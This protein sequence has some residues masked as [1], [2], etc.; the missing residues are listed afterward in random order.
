[1]QFTGV[2]KVLQKNS[3]RNGAKQVWPFE[4]SVASGGC[5]NSII[6]LVP[7]FSYKPYVLN[8]LA[9]RKFM[10]KQL[11][12]PMIF[13]QH[14]F[15]HF[16]ITGDILPTPISK[17]TLRPLDLAIQSG[18]QVRLRWGGGGGRCLKQ[19]QEILIR[20]LRLEEIGPKSQHVFPEAT[21]ATF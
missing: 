17:C 7:C 8:S 3:P 1:M 13:R 11:S 19:S 12:I 14:N 9:G 6:F 21:I 15:T 5:K 2:M 16:G 4:R 10:C 18:C 20:S